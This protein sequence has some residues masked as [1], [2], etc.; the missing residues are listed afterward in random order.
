[1][2]R[3]YADGRIFGDAYGTGSPRVLAL[4]GWRRDR[5]DFRK[6]LEGLDAIAID[7]PGFG[8]SPPPPEAWGAS[9][10]AA[11]AANL[12]REMANP[13]VVIGHSF[14]GRVAVHLAASHPAR[15]SGVVLAGVPLVRLAKAP[16][17]SMGFRIARQLH[18][19]GVL[20]DARMEALRHR[21]GS[22][23]YRAA[24]GVMRDVFVR[25]V[26]ETYEDEL[27]EIKC[28]V[29]LVWG[30]D[31]T[32]APLAVAERAVELLAHPSLTVLPGAGHL[33]PLTAPEELRAALDRLLAP[34]T[35]RR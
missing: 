31:D 29:E 32:A 21:S 10:Y 7:L 34:K 12:L 33:T 1:V 2:L 11:S 17:P 24:S 35:R 18:Q 20:T 30:R 14:G 25:L 8:A 16:A 26:N 28:P 13:I 3:V 5:S 9:D 19:W 22:S 15:V 6:V 4:H 23:D 27:R